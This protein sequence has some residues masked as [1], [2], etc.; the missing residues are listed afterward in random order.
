[1]R[2]W[3]REP[4]DIPPQLCKCVATSPPPI[5]IGYP[6]PNVFDADA[7]F[8]RPIR[9]LLPAL[10]SRE[11]FCNALP[12]YVFGV[13]GIAVLLLS[14]EPPTTG[15]GPFVQDVLALNFTRPARWLSP[16]E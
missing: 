3:H 14:F 4:P 11:R 13:G 12:G 5:K 9:D 16:E 7:A 8:G 15:A 6:L 2:M 1:M 10:P